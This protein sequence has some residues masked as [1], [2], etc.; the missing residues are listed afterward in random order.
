MSNISH[1]KVSLWLPDEFDECGNLFRKAAHFQTS[2]AA[3][4]YGKPRKQKVADWIVLAPAPH[5]CAVVAHS[6]LPR[7]VRSDWKNVK[8]VRM[9]RV[10]HLKFD[11]KEHH[12]LWQI[13][14]GHRGRSFDRNIEHGRFL[15]YC[16]KGI[17]KN[18]ARE[19]AD[20]GAGRIA[21]GRQV[22][23]ALPGLGDSE[24]RYS[25]PYPQRLLETCIYLRGKVQPKPVTRICCEMGGEQFAKS[26]IIPEHLVL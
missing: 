3:H 25:H 2:E 22:D 11:R 1:L 23:P 7:D 14:H 15:G 4:Q 21:A 16:K 18:H 13:S 5:L 10:L 12:P 17:G 8:V 19:V 24:R 9:R 26:A 6:L 20:G